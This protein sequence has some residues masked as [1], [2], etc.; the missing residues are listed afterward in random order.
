MTPSDTAASRLAARLRTV[1]EGA[2]LRHAFRALLVVAVAMI[3]LDFRD[4]VRARGG[5]L[6]PATSPVR[7]DRPRTD[8][9]IR[10]YLPRTR[11]LA[12]GETLRDRPREAIEAE[13]MRFW[14][15]TYGAA[16]AEG[17]IEPGTAEELDAFLSRDA[18]AGVTELVLHSPGGSVAD[19][20]AMAKRV[21]EAGLATRILADGYCASSCPLVFAAGTERFATS[22]SW[23][24]VH[25]VFALTNAF[26]TLADGMDQGQRVSAE[27]QTLLAE[28]GVDPK[29]WVHAM[30]TPHDRLYLFTPEELIDLKLATHLDGPASDGPRG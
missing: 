16:F 2:I 3:G 25:Q 19:A 15:G 14:L 21:R 17:T 24:G 9:Q 11:P 29:V 23:I 27:A 4:L 18:A 7:M 22:T 5:T 28:F 8:D 6:L 12:P 10:P 1:P 30:Q 26:G 20:F 13:P